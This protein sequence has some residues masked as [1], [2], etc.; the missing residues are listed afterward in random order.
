MLPPSYSAD[1]R[2][3]NDRERKLPLPVVLMRV[4]ALGRKRERGEGEGR[5]CRNIRPNDICRMRFLENE[6]DENDER[7]TRGLRN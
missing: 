3:R 7:I 6:A 1:P 2:P 4:A 5:G